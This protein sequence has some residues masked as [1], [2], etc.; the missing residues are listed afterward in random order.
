M[1]KALEYLKKSDPILRAIIESV[2]PCRMSFG[3]PEFH[4]LAESIVY[5]Q[6]NGKAA[7]TIFK[8]FA[9]LA[10]DPV[11]PEGILKLSDAQLQALKDAAAGGPAATQGNVVG[12]FLKGFDAHN[13]WLVMPTGAY[14]TN[15]TLRAVVDKVGLGA[16]TPQVSVYPLTLFDHDKAPLTGKKRYVAHFAPGSYPP[17]VK[18]FCSRRSSGI[19]E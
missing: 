7:E 4:S 11:L 15:Y 14:G 12:M 8:R 16:P 5:Q 6:L 9:A 1:R 17:P 19:S 10:G 3:P 18:F 13:G 2:G